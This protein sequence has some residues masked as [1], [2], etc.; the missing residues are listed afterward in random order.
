M[1]KS[2]SFVNVHGLFWFVLCYSGIHTPC[3]CVFFD[4]AVSI[5]EIMS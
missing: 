1:Q 4:V 2:Y 3:P 5:L